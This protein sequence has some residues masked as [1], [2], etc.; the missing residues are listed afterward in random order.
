MFGNIKVTYFSNSIVEK[1]VCWFDVSVN[2]FIFMKNFQSTQNL[3]SYFPNILLLK[4][5]LS[6]IFQI[7]DFT[8]KISSISKLHDNA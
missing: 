5:L 4:S 8:L 6:G 2:D 1:Y 3:V 7:S